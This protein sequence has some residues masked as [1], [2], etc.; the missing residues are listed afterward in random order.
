VGGYGSGG[1]RD[2]GNRLAG[3]ESRNRKRQ[4]VETTIHGMTPSQLLKHCIFIIG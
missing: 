3:R 2:R 1:N 4:A